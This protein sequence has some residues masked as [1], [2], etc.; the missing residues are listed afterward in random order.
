MARRGCD[1]PSYGKLHVRGSR[2]DLLRSLDAQPGLSL[3][4]LPARYV[5][6]RHGLPGHE[7]GASELDRRNCALRE[8][9]RN[10]SGI[11]LVLRHKA[12]FPL[13]EMAFGNSRPRRHDDRPGRIPTR[14]AGLHALPGEMARPVAVASRSSG[15]SASS[16]GFCRYAL[17]SRRTR[18]CLN[19]QVCCPLVQ[20]SR[21]R[22]A[23]GLERFLRMA[24]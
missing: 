2:L 22:Q 21:N 24:A 1:G 8:H 6:P 19:E 13:P 10:I 17:R 7:A 18:A 11:L 15:F 5:L 12:L 9:P 23:L 14:R 16:V 3:R 4:R 20:S